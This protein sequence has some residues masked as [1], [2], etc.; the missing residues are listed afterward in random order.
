M[1]ARIGRK[2]RKPK[3]DGLGPATHRLHQRLVQV[4]IPFVKRKVAEL[5]TS[6]QEQQVANGE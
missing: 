5:E 1:L 2:N 3:G 6:L 4:Q